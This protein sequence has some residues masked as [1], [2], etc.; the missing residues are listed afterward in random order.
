MLKVK[1]ENLVFLWLYFFTAFTSIYLRIF[2]KNEINICLTKI[3]EKF[4]WS[5]Y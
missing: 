5:R 3:L 2:T 1:E 4:H